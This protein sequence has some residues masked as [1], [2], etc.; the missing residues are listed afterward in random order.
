MT[1]VKNLINVLTVHFQFQYSK[2]LNWVI[3]KYGK[4]VFFLLKLI[5]ELLF[6][7]LH[8]TL[9]LCSII[10]IMSY[11]FHNQSDDIHHR[12]P[13]LVQQVYYKFSKIRIDIFSSAYYTKVVDKNY[14][15]CDIDDF[16]W[17]PIKLELNSHS[18]VAGPQTFR[19][20]LLFL[21][22]KNDKLQR[23][24]FALSCNWWL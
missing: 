6:I 3:Y 22:F 21:C 24:P 14:F 20:C 15:A 19:Y 2:Y 7:C 16:K 9:F 10:Q 4:V 17:R 1:L 12:V 18:I 8:C 13:M 23:G 5:V 11:H